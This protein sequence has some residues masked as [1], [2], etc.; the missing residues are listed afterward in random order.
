MQQTDWLFLPQQVQVHWVPPITLVSIFHP[1]LSLEVLSAIDGEWLKP[2]Q[3][4]SYTALQ[5]PE[6]YL[7]KCNFSL[8]ATTT[9]GPLVSF[10]LQEAVPPPP[11]QLKKSQHMYEGAHSCQRAEVQLKRERPQSQSWGT[12]PD[13]R[14]L[15]QLVVSYL[16]GLMLYGRWDGKQP[17]SPTTC[18]RGHPMAPVLKAEKH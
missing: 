15:T 3:D 9:P 16:I 10:S 8:F 17:T 4:P 2:C 13:H 6:Q 18:Y 11:Q 7:P 12:S 1:P 5:Y 14:N